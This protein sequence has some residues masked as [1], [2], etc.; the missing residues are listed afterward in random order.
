MT[1][2]SDNAARFASRSVDVYAAATRCV[3]R[4]NTRYLLNTVPEP[5]LLDD[6]EDRAL[7]VATCVDSIRECATSRVAG[8]AHTP[9]P[10]SAWGDYQIILDREVERWGKR[11]LRELRRQRSIA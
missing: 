1:V 6:H 10:R 8:N 3:T 7:R 9:D 2:Y 4:A 5:Q 11:R